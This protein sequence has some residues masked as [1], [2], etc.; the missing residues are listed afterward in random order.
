MQQGRP[1]AGA[2]AVL[3]VAGA[4]GWRQAADDGMREQE[5]L[6][7]A[8]DRV[9]APWRRGLEEEND[10]CESGGFDGDD[11]TRLERWGSNT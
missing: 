10:G 6:G 11:R 8:G 9:M 7:L 5:E 1:Q 3:A 2:A 4:R